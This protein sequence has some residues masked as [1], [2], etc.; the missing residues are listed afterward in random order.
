MNFQEHSSHAEAAG[1]FNTASVQSS[2]NL[3]PAYKATLSKHYC[4]NITE[5]ITDDDTTLEFGSDAGV[6]SHWRDYE[7]LA[8]YTFLSH[9]ALLPFTRRNGSIA[10]V[11]MIP[12]VGVF[13]AARWESS[14]IILLPLQA[15]LVHLLLIIPDE[16]EKIENVI[17]KLHKNTLPNLIESLPKEEI[18]IF[19]PQ[20]TAISKNL[21]LTSLLRHNGIKL[22]FDMKKANFTKAADKSNRLYLKKVNQNAYFSTSFVALNSVAGVTSSLGK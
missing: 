21:N 11:P 19:I 5:L 14:E 9:Q 3:L 12:Q 17:N 20:L 4:A 15:K 1:S 18:E 7:K 22:A 10:H 2:L 13:K 6:M 16:V 8:V